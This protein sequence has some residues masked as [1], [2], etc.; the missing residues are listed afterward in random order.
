MSHRKY[1]LVLSFIF[2]IEFLI[3]AIS[4]YDR[5]DWALENALVLVFVI[6]MAFTYKKFSFSRISYTLIFIFMCLHEIGAHYTYAKVPYDAF[7][8]TYFNFS[9]NDLMGWE[10]NHFDRLVH[11]LYGLFMAYPFRE[12]YCRIAYGKGFWGYLLPLLFTIAASVTFELFEWAAAELFGGDLGVAYL[13]TQGDVW[14]AQKDMGLAS[15]GAFVAMLIV[16]AI[17]LRIQKDFAREWRNSLRIKRKKPLG[18]D[19]IARLLDE[20]D[21]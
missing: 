15:L 21:K 20:H 11:F 3:L 19:E 13:G 1:F 12:I 9:L 5:S 17:N 10:R 8:M 6:I 18:E 4:P 16:I 2:F 7:L 14:D